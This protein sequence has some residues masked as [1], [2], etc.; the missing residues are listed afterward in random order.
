L[1]AGGR[2]QGLI[3]LAVGAIMALAWL[4]TFTRPDA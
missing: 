1:A 2:W 3:F 4:P